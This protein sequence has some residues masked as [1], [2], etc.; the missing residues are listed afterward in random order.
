VSRPRVAIAHDYLTQRGGAER[1]VLAL[2]RAFPDAA[3]H[4]LLYDADA[5]FPE[6][7]DVRVVTSPLNRVGPLRRHHRLALPLLAPVASR[8]TVDADVTVVSTSGWAHGFDVRGHSVVYC[9]NPA[10]WLYQGAE[11]LG[12]HPRRLMSLALGT[13]APPLR[14]W[15]HAAMRR[16]DTHLVNSTVVR[17][18]VRAT[19]GIDATI[20][21]PPAAVGVD[22]PQEAVG[23]F[24]AD[25]HLVVSRLLPY[26]NVDRAIEAFGDLSD[27]R[28]LVIGRGPEEERLRRLLPPNVAIVSDVSDAQLR[29]AYQH[30]VAL[31]APALED[32]GLT[33]L[34]VGAFGRPTL[35]LRGGGYLDTVTDGVSGLFFDRAEAADIAATVRRSLTTGWDAD[36]IRDHGR[37]FD[38]AHFRS[39][40]VAAAERAVSA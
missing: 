14:R 38:E 39:A 30:S 27:E 16:H 6:F 37:R 22:G 31:V 3:V 19:Y 29:W 21:F 5:T 40:I 32:L 35:A 7:R 28:L 24:D 8:M 20:L 15:D 18:R 33:P 12:E 26:K 23:P 1:V 34:E 13:L 17:E 4:T 11:Y 36:A 2:L 10:R 25:F 9:H